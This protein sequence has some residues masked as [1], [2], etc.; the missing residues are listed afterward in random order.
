MRE[1]IPRYYGISLCVSQNN[2]KRRTT[3]SVERRR[4]EI[5]NPT[6]ETH[7]G[8]WHL[9]CVLGY[10]RHRQTYTGTHRRQAGLD[11]TFFLFL[12]TLFTFRRSKKRSCCFIFTSTP[13]L[14]QT[15]KVFPKLLSSFFWCSVVCFVRVYVHNLYLT[16][17]SIKDIKRLERP[18]KSWRYGF[19][20]FETWLITH[21]LIAHKPTE[22]EIRPERFGQIQRWRPRKVCITFFFFTPVVSIDFFFFFFCEAVLS[23]KNEVSFFSSMAC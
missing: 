10:W 6:R 20:T 15:E 12:K 2:L 23:F 3:H 21:S 8:M 4:S 9:W 14:A 18:W 13:W 7:E 22:E 5:D 17:F 19:L 16:A 1:R 11:T